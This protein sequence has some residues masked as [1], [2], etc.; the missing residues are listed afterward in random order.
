MNVLQSCAMRDMREMGPRGALA[1]LA[2]SAP[3]LVWGMALLQTLLGLAAAGRWMATGN[4]GHLA[5]YTQ[6]GG[7]AILVSFAIVEYLMCLTA[8]QLFGFGDK[9]RTAWFYMTFAAGCR[10]VGLATASFLSGLSDR[11]AA[12]ANPVLSGSQAEGLRGLG[13]AIFGPFSMGALALGLL[14]VLRLYKEAGVLRR[15]HRM[16][17]VLLAMAAVFLLGQA[18]G[19]ARWPEAAATPVTALK[20][21]SWL[22]GP[23][24]GFLLLEAVL[25][26]R[27]VL[28]MGGGLIGWCWSAYTAG[29]FLTLLGNA[30]TWAMN[31]DYVP[32]PFVCLTSYVWF[33]AAAAFALGPAYQVEAIMRARRP[34]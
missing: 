7:A 31:H 13:L 30:G 19:F 4:L 16:D 15:P 23:L 29:I 28:T 18:Y 2:V 32:G 33:T 21:A 11:A 25:V 14:V 6:Q 9:L 5:Y 17:F 24:L 22:S 3:K 20:G 34:K 26:R 10:V 27:A 1:G 8:W 12:S